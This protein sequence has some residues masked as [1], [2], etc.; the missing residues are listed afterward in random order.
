[1]GT[2][3]SSAVKSMLR[4]FLLFHPLERRHRGETVPPGGS[5]ASTLRKVGRVRVGGRSLTDWARWV[6]GRATPR[7][8]ATA[9]CWCL[10]RQRRSGD[11]RRAGRQRWSRDCCDHRTRGSEPGGVKREKRDSSNARKKKGVVSSSGCMSI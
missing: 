8:P 7:Q 3:L 9:R 6:E 4:L 5:T 2:I 10:S 1:M 11:C